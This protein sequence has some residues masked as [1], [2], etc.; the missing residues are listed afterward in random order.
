MPDQMRADCMSAAGHPQIR[1]PNIDRLAAEGVRF[2]EAHTVSPLCM[3]ARASFING[4]YPHNHGMWNNRG[5]M[6]AGDETFFHHL[7]AAGYYTAHIGKSHYY[8][9]GRG[10]LRDHEDYMHARGLNYVHETTGPWATLTTDSYLTDHWQPL[11]LVEAF[12]ADYRDRQSSP[13]TVVRASPLPVEEFPDS[14]VGRQAVQFIDTYDRHKPTA[15]FVGFGGPHEPWDAPGEY[16]TMYDPAQTPPAIPPGEPGDRLPDYARERMRRDMQPGM[17]DADVAAIRANYYG[18]ITL[19]D[20]WVGQILGA[21]ARRA[22]LD[23]AFTVFWSDHGEMAGDHGRLYKSIFFNAAVNVPLILRW[24]GRIAPARTCDAL[25]E[26][27]DVFPTLLEGLGLESSP[28]CLGRS[29][30]PVLDNTDRPHREAAFSEVATQG[31]YGTMIRTNRHKYVV[32]QQGCGYQLFALEADANEQ[33]NLV[34]R[35]DAK[36]VEAELRERLLRFY[37]EAQV[38]L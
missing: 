24:P 3:P 31:T 32:D 10:H 33:C 19:V 37:L 8:A 23:S 6:P 12:R 17:T 14:Y 18:K 36:G 21:L 9:H 1:T 27:I 35:P 13:R 25:V 2:T 38:R 5:R 29:L 28:R 16:A 15:L 11:G 20:H 7:Q 22:W 30:W 34:G 26:I 4:L